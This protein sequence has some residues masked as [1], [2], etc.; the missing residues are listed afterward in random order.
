[1]HFPLHDHLNLPCVIEQIVPGKPHP[2]G[3]R[4]LPQ[5]LL[6]PYG[7]D[8][9]IGVVDRHH[10]VAAASSGQ[11]GQ[12]RLV[13][14][15]GAVRAQTPPYRLGLEHGPGWRGGACFDPHILG[16]VHSIATWEPAGGPLAQATVYSELSLDLGMG[17]VGL[18][19]NLDPAALTATTLAPGDYLE[20]THARIDILSFTPSAP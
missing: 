9:L 19:A 6:R 16:R 1:M 17:L 4:Y 18:R 15:M 10:R 7:T 2:D 14:A 5:I 3:R 12:A 11:A 8:M 13:C 20:L